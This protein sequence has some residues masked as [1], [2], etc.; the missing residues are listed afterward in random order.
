MPKLQTKTIMIISL[1]FL[2][3]FF[4]MSKSA[5]AAGHYVRSDAAGANNGN[6]WTNAWTAMP[7]TLTRGDIYYIADGSYG[8]YTFDDA[9]SGSTYI[10]IKKAIQSDHGTDTGWQSGFG[11]GTADF[12]SLT[13]NSSYWIFD[14]MVGGGPGSWNAGH[15]FNIYSTDNILIYFTG[16][17]SNIAIKH[18]KADSNRGDTFIAGLKATTGSCS[19]IMISYCQFSNI[20]GPVFHINNW[21][22]SIIEYSYLY[23]NKSTA[24]MHSEGISSIGA[25]NNLTI[26]YNIWDRIDGTAIFAGVNSGSSANWKI[27]GNIFS[28]S[29]T[30]IYYYWESGTNQNSMNNLAFYNNNIVGIPSTSQGGI[31][32]QNGSGNIVQ[33]NIWY[34]NDAN[35][36]GISGTHDYNFAA[37]NIRTADCSPACDKNADLLSGES[38]GQTTSGGPFINYQADPIM[39]DF[40]LAKAT[41]N[42]LLLS[43]P[44]NIDPVGAIRGADGVWDRGAYEYASGGSADTTPPAAPKNAKVN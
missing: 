22:D 9:N 16:S 1:F 19:N 18:T 15:G 7:A 4:S 29:V 17:V 6:D 33:N 3:A 8:S 25:N 37:N 11:D 44:Y 12:S 10:T 21:S 42:G 2:F 41:N 20:F 39:A 35:A 30:T 40:R 5:N 24:A 14:G 43:S 36:F 23:Y 31:E 27:Y 32:I 13:Y 26:R 38:H 28:R 34:N